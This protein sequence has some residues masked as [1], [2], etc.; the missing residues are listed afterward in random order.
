MATFNYF[1][2]AKKRQ[3]A[4]V[5]IRL[6]AGRGTDLIVKSGLIVEP[7]RWSNKTQN[8]K[9]RITSDADEKLIKKLKALR[10][11]I[12]GKIRNHTNGFTKEWLEAIIFEF[13]NKKSLDAKTL[14]EYIAQYISDAKEGNRKNRNSF[15]FSPG[16]I[17][18]WEGFQR[19]FN[20]FQ[21]VYTDKRRN[22]LTEKKKTLRPLRILDFEDITLSFYESFKTFLS[23]E[24]YQVNTIGR[25]IKA[26]KY[27]MQKSLYEK[28]HTSREFQNRDA[29]KIPSEHSFAVY[30]TQDEV[31]KIYR[32][33]LKDYPRMELARDAFIVLCETALRI[34]DYKNIDV[35]IREVQGKKLIYIIQKKTGT[36]VVIPASKRMIELLTKYD[37][38]LPSIPD[39]YI[40]EYIK[41]VAKLC[42]I[43]E[44]LH[45]QGNKFGK[46]YDK[47]AKKYELITCHTGR[48]TAA[49]NMVKVGIPIPYIMS[50]TGHKSEKQL[51]EYVR[52][53]PEE[54]ALELAEH[55]FYN[56]NL[57]IV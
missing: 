29:F 33:D 35:N 43:D 53:T 24:G 42:G 48:R 31:E 8:I 39:Q 6:S 9:Q 57:K 32:Y 55:S 15:N 17:R 11:T 37:N 44:V 50:I 27:F 52:L 46:K 30:L 36:P 7:A 10:E 41:I 34:S 3:T 45:W 28:K 56:Q 49:T 16:T 1:V 19:I 47:T 25:F 20:E 26:L 40:N 2:S 22:E 4:P 18:T 51:L 54:I 14:N 23:N 21:G 5:Y 38:K 13:H 12:E